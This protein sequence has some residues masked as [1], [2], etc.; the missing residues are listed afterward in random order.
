[1]ITLFNPTNE[2]LKMMY[3]GIAIVMEP[4][5]APSHRL[6]VEDPCGKHLLNAFATRGLCQLVY[7]DNEEIVGDAGRDRNT[8]F[9]KA[10]IVRY[11][12]M[13]EQ[14]KMSGMGYLPPTEDVKRYA[15]ELGIKLLEP[16]TMKDA[17]VT[18]IHNAAKENQEL[19]GQLQTQQTEINDLKFRLTQLVGLMEGMAGAEKE[20]RKQSDDGP[21][22]PGRPRKDALSKILEDDA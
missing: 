12:T 22:L 11:N 7:G 20:A 19:K 1:M 16:Y 18:A 4:P 10:Q 9:K 21:R 3:G 14:R 13:N 6:N 8:E 17:E 15:F 5:P 2:T